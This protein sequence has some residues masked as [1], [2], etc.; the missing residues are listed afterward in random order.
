MKA[1]CTTDFCFLLL[2]VFG[3]PDGGGRVLGWQQQLTTCTPLQML[4]LWLHLTLLTLALLL[5]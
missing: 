4:A 3:A 1:Q 2:R 5:E